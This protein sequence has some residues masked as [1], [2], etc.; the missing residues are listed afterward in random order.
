LE[1]KKNPVTFSYNDYLNDPYIYEKDMTYEAW[2]LKNQ[3]EDVS[4]C[5]ECGG[6]VFLDV[7]KRCSG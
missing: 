2:V 4:I 5:E 3:Y 7:C 6:M 1:R